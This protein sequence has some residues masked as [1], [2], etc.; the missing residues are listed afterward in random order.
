MAK[1]GD[2]LLILSAQ[3]T[4]FRGLGSAQGQNGFEQ[5]LGLCH[6]DWNYQ[7][8]SWG[9]LKKVWRKKCFRPKYEE[10]TVEAL[11]VYK[12]ILPDLQFIIPDRMSLM[13]PSDSNG[14]T[15][16]PSGQ[17]RDKVKL[18]EHYG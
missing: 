5:C 14:Q 6:T 10:I 15:I 16:P 7:K 4:N 12:N 9:F 8:K 13:L 17:F 11:T 18:L 3:K 1:L 2:G